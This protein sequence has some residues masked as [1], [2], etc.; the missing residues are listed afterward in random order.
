MQDVSQ[1]KATAKALRAAFREESVDITHARALEIVARQLGFANWNVF[2]AQMKPANAKV[3]IRPA[4]PIIRIFDEE[5]ALDF[6]QD[7]L[8]FAV[9]WKHRHTPDLPLSAQ[10]SR[11]GCLLHLSG[12]HGDATPG[13]RSFTRVDGIEALQLELKGRNYPNLNPGLNRQ[14]WGL[15]VSLVDPFGNHLTFCEQRHSM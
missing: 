12:H 5:K 15:E 14:P 6:Y 2:S 8:G 3:K 9:D 1:A 4:I 10:L 7:Y 13:G 11:D